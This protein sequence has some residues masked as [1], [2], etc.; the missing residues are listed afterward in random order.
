MTP[1]DVQRL[2]NALGDEEQQ[3]LLQKKLLQQRFKGS[4]D[5]ERD[6]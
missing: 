5:M 2:L 1:K 3:K 6:W 4:L